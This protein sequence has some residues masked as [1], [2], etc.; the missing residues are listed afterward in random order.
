M[1]PVIAVTLGSNGFHLF[2]VR[3]DGNKM[4]TTHHLYDNVQAETHI[5]QDD[6]ISDEGIEKIS[7]SL[8]KFKAYISSNPGRLV[9]AIATGTFRRAANS[10]E[11]LVAAEA[12]LG[13]K[14]NVLSGQGESLFCY[15]GIASSH[16]VVPHNRLVIDVGGGSTELMIATES[17][18]VEYVS[19]DVGCVSMTRKYFPENKVDVSHF[20]EAA[21]MVAEIVQPSADAFRQRGWDEVLGCGGT[22]SSLF[23]VLQRNRMGGRSVTLAGLERFRDAVSQAGNP[24]DVCLV[25][26]PADRSRLLPAGA[27]ILEGV[28]RALDIERLT[29]AFT[30]VGQGLIMQLFRQQS[31]G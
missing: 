16:G 14:I 15:I 19:F 18:L 9:G 30:S 24:D 7:R 21:A 17:R 23:S 29:P 3:L 22:V 25:A 31:N 28:Y 26:V 10:D 8:G 4:E 13:Q 27:S 2:D 20:N 6:R 11:L 1:K 5:G 12:A